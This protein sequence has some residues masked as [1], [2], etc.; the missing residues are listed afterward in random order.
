MYV[1]QNFGVGYSMAPADTS[2]MAAWTFLDQERVG[3]TKHPPTHTHILL[4]IQ[5]SNIACSAPLKCVLSFRGLCLTPLSTSPSCAQAVY[6]RPKLNYLG[7][8]TFSY[9]IMVGVRPSEK[10]GTVSVNVRNC[11]SRSSRYQDAD[12]LCGCLPTGRLPFGDSIR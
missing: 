6:Y 3:H 11:R 10:Q 4:H 2:D 8:D 12:P 1:S 7:P 5:I 9:E